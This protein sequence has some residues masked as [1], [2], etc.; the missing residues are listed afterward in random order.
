DE[1]QD[2]A[3]NRQD[4][5]HAEEVSVENGGAHDGHSARPVRA[6]AGSRIGSSPDRPDR[7]SRNLQNSSASRRSSGKGPI[8]AAASGVSTG[9]GYSVTPVSARCSSV[10]ARGM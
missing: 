9:S 3:R 6:V 1:A 7:A 10:S 2:G 4:E 8:R 5:G